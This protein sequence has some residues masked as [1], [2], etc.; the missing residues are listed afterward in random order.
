MNDKGL[1]MGWVEF[2]TSQFRSG[3]RKGF[4]IGSGAISIEITNGH[5]LYP[6]QWVYQCRALNLSVR[7]INALDEGEAKKIA[8]MAV[9]AALDALQQDYDHIKGEA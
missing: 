6:G 2:D 7:P 4:A 3:V 5:Y 9:E 8:I 1:F